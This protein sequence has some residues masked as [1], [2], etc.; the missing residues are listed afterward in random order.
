MKSDNDTDRV[1]KIINNFKNYSL[2]R[3]TLHTEDFVAI[4]NVLKELETYKKIVD[5]MTEIVKKQNVHYAY[6]GIT[7][8]IAGDPVIKLC[9]GTKCKQCI[10]DWARNEVE[11]DE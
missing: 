9:D 3:M 10:I 2:H 5:F 8:C 1:K 11:K 6:G 4:E 7:Q